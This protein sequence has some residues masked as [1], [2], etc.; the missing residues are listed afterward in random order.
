MWTRPLG[1]EIQNR[2]S[3]QNMI[4]RQ[5]NAEIRLTSYEVPGR[6]TGNRG[7]GGPNRLGEGELG[8]GLSFAFSVGFVSGGIVGF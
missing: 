1:P 5:G 3:A 8:G 2:A 7:R 6:G 4:V